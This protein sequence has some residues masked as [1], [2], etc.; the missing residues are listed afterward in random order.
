MDTAKP[1]G[2]PKLF[3]KAP[4]QR[5]VV[6]VRVRKQYGIDRSA[7]YGTEQGS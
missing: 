2:S 3:P 7:S 6:A 1:Q 5:A 4:G